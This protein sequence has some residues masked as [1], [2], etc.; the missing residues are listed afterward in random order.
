[1]NVALAFP[2]GPFTQEVLLLFNFA[3]EES[4]MLK[5]ANVTEYVDSFKVKELKAKMANGLPS[6]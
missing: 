4:D 5:I 3:K 1:M 2:S 6:S